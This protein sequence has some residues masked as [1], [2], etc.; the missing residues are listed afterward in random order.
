MSPRSNLPRRQRGFTLVEA[1]VVVAIAGVLATA[2]YPS[3]MEQ[4]GRSRRADA[5]AVLMQAAQFLEGYHTENMRYD[6]NVVGQAMALPARLT[7]S[8]L[9]GATKYYTVSLQSVAAQT[10]TLGA[11]PRGSQAGD[12][13][14]TLTMS[15]T[16][17]KS[18]AL[19]D[20]WAR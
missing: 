17:V 7:Q 13:C 6:Q 16:G 11:V 9:D 4:V 2:A 5:Q 12:R 3:Y 18:A 20:C 14:G 10:Y 8:P 15:H 1:M 19:G